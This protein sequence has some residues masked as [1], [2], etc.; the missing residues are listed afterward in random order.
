MRI[1]ELSESSNLWTHLALLGLPWS[2]Y[3]SVFLTRSALGDVSRYPSVFRTKIQHLCRGGIHRSV[4]IR[5]SFH[6]VDSLTWFL[7]CVLLSDA[8]ICPHENALIWSEISSVSCS[9]VLKSLL[10][11]SPLFLLNATFDCIQRVIE[12]LGKSYTFWGPLYV[13]IVA[14]W[15]LA[16]SGWL[17][18]EEG[19]IGGRLVMDSLDQSFKTSGLNSASSL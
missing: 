2:T 8:M 10:I 11:T 3:P 4:S 7:V 19:P 17:G 12:V 6:F 18:S 15:R 1:A 5:L 13:A 9:K 16:R 14:Y